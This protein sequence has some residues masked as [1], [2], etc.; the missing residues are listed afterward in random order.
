MA[1]AEAGRGGE[2]RGRAGREGEGCK[3]G[4]R[5]ALRMGK[6]RKERI[7]TEKSAERGRG[8]RRGERQPRTQS[9]PDL[10]AEKS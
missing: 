2:G 5:G 3:E 4:G 9:H 8:A 6:T 7:E 10:E 1:A